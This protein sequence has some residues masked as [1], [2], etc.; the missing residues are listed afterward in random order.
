MK[1]TFLGTGGSSPTKDRNMP[2]VAL[3]YHGDI[4]MFDCGEGTQRQCMTYSVN[5]SKIKA[6]FISHAHGDHIIGIAGLVRTMALYRRAQPLHIF[7]PQG[8]EETIGALLTFDRAMIS[9]KIIVKGVKPGPVYDGEGFKVTAFKLNHTV[10]TLGYVFEE[11]SRTRFFKDK[12]KKLGLKGEMFHEL[13]KKGSVKV[14]SKT[15]RLKDVTYIV[16]GKK[17]VYATDTRP[18]DTTVKA[19]AGAD[20]LIHEASYA[21]KQ[22]ELA[23][24]RSHCTSEEAAKIA[25]KAKCNRLVLF[26]TSA[27]YKDARELLNE[28]KKIFKNTESQMTA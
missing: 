24:E 2:A 4:Y 27:R 13:E 8:E 6:I 3:E 11:K 19:A 1:L 14:G 12:C 20:I 16:K 7:V 9:Y 21:S 5:M 18:V 23:K 28:A 17:I 22:V 25:K 10:P 15:I 26:H